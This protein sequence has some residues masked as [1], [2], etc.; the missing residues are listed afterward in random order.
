MWKTVWTIKVKIIS[1]IAD[2]AWRK[3]RN[4]ARNVTENVFKSGKK[5]EVSVI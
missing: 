5:E 1:E 2:N 4:D 3:V